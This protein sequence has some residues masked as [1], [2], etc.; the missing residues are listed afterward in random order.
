MCAVRGRTAEQLDKALRDAFRPPDRLDMLLLYSLDRHRHDITMADDYPARVFHLIQSAD[1]EGWLAD[2]VTAALEARPT[3][4]GL[5]SVA[6]ALG[7]TALSDNAE[8]FIDEHVPFQDTRP[9][10]Q[11]LGA[12]EGQV[13]RLELAGPPARPL[14]TG[15]LVGPDV[16]L[17]AGHVVD[18]LRDE[19]VAP[20]EVVARFDFRR[21]SDGRVVSEG[22]AYPLARRWRVATYAASAAD[23]SPDRTRLPGEDELDVAL[24]RLAE[25][26]GLDAVGRA[27]QVPDSP[28]RGWLTAPGHDDALAADRPLIMLQ[29]P[30]REP[31]QLA[32]GTVLDVNAN[33]TRLRHRVNTQRGSSGSPCFTTDLT[34]VG[35]HIAGDPDDRQ[36]HE[37]TYNIAVPMATIL[38]RLRRDGLASVVFP[39]L[40]GT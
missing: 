1:A 13:C 27:G 2:L 9:W 4:S 15:F 18:A 39:A 14:G 28:R 16:C 21:A 30:G 40:P 24:I 11:R 29:Y 35:L 31:L 37:P 8:R 36:D 38:A 19:Q 32:F 10:R 34:L 26:A 17:T 3:H 12:L 6:T 5:R 25:P 33:R 20:D 23:R 22:S 7:L